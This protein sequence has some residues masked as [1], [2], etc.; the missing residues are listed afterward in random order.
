MVSHTKHVCCSWSR[1][2][3][4]FWPM[5]SSAHQPNAVLYLEYS[6][7]VYLESVNTSILL[8]FDHM[9]NMDHWKTILE[10]LSLSFLKICLSYRF[11]YMATIFNMRLENFLCNLNASHLSNVHNG[12][13]YNIVTAVVRT[14]LKFVPLFEVNASFCRWNA[15]QLPKNSK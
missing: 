8:I 6:N 13:V 3:Y 5:V 10:N 14:I 7:I 2:R 4:L 15:E 9:K 12:D 11:S 1:P